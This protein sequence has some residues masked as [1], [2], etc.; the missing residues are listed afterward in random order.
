MGQFIKAGHGKLPKY[1]E[2][3]ERINLPIDLGKVKGHIIDNFTFLDVEANNHQEAFCL[4]WDALSVFLQHLSVNDGTLFTAAPIIIETDDGRV[5]PIPTKGRMGSYKV[6]NLEKLAENIVAVQRFSQLSDAR[7]RKALNY[8]EYALWLYERAVTIENV[9]SRHYPY[10][11]SMVFLN[12][13]KSITT[14]VGDPTK[15]K[16]GY[17][18]RYRKIGLKQQDKINIDALKKLRDDHD[19]AH[20]ALTEES[21]KDVQNK[22]G[23]AMKTAAEV[24][25]T[26]REHLL[27]RPKEK[28]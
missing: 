12:L 2:E 7:L 19:V 17:Q 24:I 21:L 5:Y 16:D 28:E 1:R 4:T 10:L 25:R 8:F 6:Y 27:I 11:I 15:S 3:S 26:Y 13:W 23:V 18:K 20:Y 22:F 9:T 14:I